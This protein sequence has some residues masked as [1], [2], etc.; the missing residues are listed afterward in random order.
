L[1]QNGSTKEKNFKDALAHAEGSKSLACGAIDQVP[2]MQQPRT[3]PYRLPFLWLLPRP[4]S[5]D[6]RSRLN[7]AV[8][9]K[10]WGIALVRGFKIP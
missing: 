5:I 1:S 2:A 7:G 8:A 10:K 6:H 4:P 9:P 3:R